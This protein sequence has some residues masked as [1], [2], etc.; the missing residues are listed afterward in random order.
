MVGV[1]CESSVWE[2]LYLALDDVQRQQSPLWRRD[3]GVFEPLK[4]WVVPYY[5]STPAVSF[6]Y[7]EFYPD[8][9]FK[10]PPNDIVAADVAVIYI[11]TR[12]LSFRFY[13]MKQ[14]AGAPTVDKQ[15]A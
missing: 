6:P 12:E 14:H 3:P 13:I 10:L 15:K 1:K 9:G 11:S 4:L 5:T 8:H 7:N 2:C